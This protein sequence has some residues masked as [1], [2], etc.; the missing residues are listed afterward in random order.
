[1][2]PPVTIVLQ[3]DGRDA[4]VKDWFT[5]LLFLES[6]TCTRIVH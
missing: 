1:M 6:P 5:G 2:A 4:T 3:F